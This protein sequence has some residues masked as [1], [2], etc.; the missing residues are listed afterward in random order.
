MIDPESVK[1]LITNKTKVILPTQ[2]NGRCCQMD[3]LIKIAEDND[4]IIIEDAAQGLGAKYKGKGIGTFGKGATISFYPAKNLG[5]FGLIN[6]L[7]SQ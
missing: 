3:S 1:A 2:L 5:S 6:W 4:L 7:Y